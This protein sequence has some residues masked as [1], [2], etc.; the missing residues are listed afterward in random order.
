MKEKIVDDWK[1]RKIGGRNVNKIKRCTK[2][3]LRVDERKWRKDDHSNQKMS[4]K[5]RQKRNTN[6]NKRK[7]KVPE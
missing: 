4:D 6:G 1:I 7:A 2:Q 5:D 3:K